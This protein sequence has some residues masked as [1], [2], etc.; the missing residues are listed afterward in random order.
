M[1]AGNPI[2]GETLLV[3]A[4][5][6]YTLVYD[7]R[8]LARMAHAVGA[9]AN[10]YDLDT[11]ATVIV[12][13]LEK[14]HGSI[15]PD[16]LFEASPPPSVPINGFNNALQM[17]YYGH[18]MPPRADDGNADSGSVGGGGQ[19]IDRLDQIAKAFGVAYRVGIR[20]GEFWDMTPFQT[21]LLVEANA[22]RLRD[23]FETLLSASWHTALFSRAKT[24]P[25]LK[26]LFRRGPDPTE[27]LDGDDPDQIAAKQ[28]IATMMGATKVRRIITQGQ[29]PT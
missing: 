2:E 28:M 20:P 16:L 18:R 11:L 17:A 27:V 15:G 23:E 14:C 10:L 1:L 6:P 8:A 21:N 13:G 12:I 25:P 9:T 22:E 19:D 7:W 26:S 29:S 5:V 3:L 4:G 24:M